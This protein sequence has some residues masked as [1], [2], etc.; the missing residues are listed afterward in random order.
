ME[1][2]NPVARAAGA[3]REKDHSQTII[4]RLVYPPYHLRDLLRP[5]AV[6]KDRPDTAR[7]QSQAG[8]IGYVFSGYKDAFK[9]G[10]VGDDVDIA[11]MVRH[12]KERSPRRLACLNGATG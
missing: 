2:P 3:F 12:Q 1:G 10:R 7:Q 6:D 8:P 9:N 11:Q 4:Q 5:F